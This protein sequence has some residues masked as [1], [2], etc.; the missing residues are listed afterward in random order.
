MQDH[1]RQQQVGVQPRVL[2]QDGLGQPQHP[3]G[4]VQKPAPLGVVDPLGGGIIQQLFPETIQHFPGDEPQRFAGKS[5][6]RVIKL[7]QHGL[8]GFRGAG[9][10]QGQI[11][12]IPLR[13]GADTLHPQ[14]QATVVFQRR[15]PYLDDGAGRGTGGVAVPDLGVDLA[16]AVGQVHIQIFCAVAAGALIRRTNQQKAFKLLILAKLGN[17]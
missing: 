2:G 3:R 17:G 1:A 6:R 16:G 13:H 4:V 10:Q 9:S 11:D 15:A 8:R 12:G 7:L 14:L 5:V